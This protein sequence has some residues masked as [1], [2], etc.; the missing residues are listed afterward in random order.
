ME[1]SIMEM[2]KGRQEMK[3]VS[4]RV[5]RM[6]EDTVEQRPRVDA[7]R[8][9]FLMEIYNNTNGDPTI[10]TRAK[11]FEK[12]CRE[13]TIF[14]DENPLVGTLTRYINGVYPYPEYYCRWMRK[15]SVICT[16]MGESPMGENDEERRLIQESVDYFEKRCGSYRTRQTVSELT[17]VDYLD[18]SKCGVWTNEAI[19]STMVNLADYAKVLTVGLKGIIAEA[20]DLARD[21]DVGDVESFDAWHFRKAAIMCL[22]AVITLAGRYAALAR[23]MAQDGSI[24]PERKVELLRIAEACE[25]VPANPARSF[26]EALQSVWFIQVASWIQQPVVT[27]PPGRFPQYMYPFYKMDKEKGII[28][29]EEVI[30]L[31]H[32]WFLG[33]QRGLAN[34]LMSPFAMRFNSPSLRQHLALGGYTPLGEDAT[35]EVDF[36]VL[37]AKRR[38]SIPEPHILVFY[39]NKLSQEF[40]SKCV[41]VVK[42]GTGQ[43]AFFNADV[44]VLRN[45]YHRSCQGV[46]MEE[47]RDNAVLGCVQNIIPGSSD[48]YW[49]GTLN[50]AKMLELALNNGKDMLRGDQI[51][52]QTGDI[53]SFQSYEDVVEAVK[54]QLQYFLPFIRKIGKVSWNIIREDLPVPFTSALTNDCIAKGKDMT[55]SG[56]RFSLA[57]GTIFI[58]T[59]DLANSLSAIK[60]LVFEEKTIT[61]SQLK[62]SLVANF[63]GDSHEEIQNMLINVPKYG[64][65]DPYADS[66]VREC[67]QMLLEEFEKDN[68]D[69]LGRPLPPDALSLTAHADRGQLT[70]A[71]PS[72]RKA[73]LALTDASVSAFPGT[74]MEGPTALIKSAAPALDTVKWG[75]NHFNVRLHPSA[76]DA[77]G[78]GKDKFL[79]LLKTYMDL[80]GYHIQFNCLDS[81]TLEDARVHPENYRDLVVRVA[82]FSAYFIYLDETTQ[83]ELIRRT[84]H[85][86][87]R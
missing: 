44:A 38:L 14:I 82:G 71:L 28:T 3:M 78:G 33:I 79:A 42:T 20:E 55:D 31:L 86:F 66:V 39:H 9:K 73:G 81:H 23:D 56:A 32:L 40:L 59:V 12:M 54:K 11:H 48:G 51:G 62:E 84:I 15:H 57:S 21:V 16:H 80:G 2:D 60:K 35:N 52:P 69:Y 25:W 50:V 5:R 58:G 37:E 70:A 26:Y 43:P 41:D 67:Y 24:S 19:D 47:A 27:S 34:Y 74:D 17:G 1:A 46:T 8:V 76:L 7:E 83:D 18:I 72:G 61:M 77:R 10:I 45:M 13:K 22:K 63:E 30:E 6:K 36:L 75:T 4:D 68:L 87:S 49:E 29:D 64:N 85:D 65:D 53:E